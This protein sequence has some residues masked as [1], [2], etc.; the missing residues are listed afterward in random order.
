MWQSSWMETVGGQ[1]PR[2]FP[3]L[4]AI[5]VEQKPSIES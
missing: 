3:E 1:N 5:G 4:K 2:A